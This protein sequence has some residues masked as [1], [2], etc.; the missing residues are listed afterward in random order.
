MSL[1]NE[2]EY[3]EDTHDSFGE[4]TGKMLNY[5]KEQEQT[6]MAQESSNFQPS[7]EPEYEERTV[8]AI[9]PKRVEDAQDVIDMIIKRQPIIINFDYCSQEVAQRILDFVS[10]AT[11]ALGGSVDKISGNVFLIVPEKVKVIG[12]VKG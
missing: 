12:E 9:N 1:D 7:S 8:S 3:Y 2:F 4:Y 6:K 10:G 11:Y 5:I